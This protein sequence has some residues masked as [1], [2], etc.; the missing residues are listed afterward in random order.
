MFFDVPFD[1][2]NISLREVL[3]GGLDADSNSVYQNIVSY[4]ADEAFLQLINQATGYKSDGDISLRELAAHILLTACTRTISKDY[5]AGLERFIS[6][7]H[8]SYCY[9]FV[10]DWIRSDDHISFRYIAEEIERELRL[11]SRFKTMSIDSLYDTE[12]F[13][14]ISEIIL[15]KLMTDIQNEIIPAE[16]IIKCNEKRRT[17]VWHSDVSCYYDGLVAIADMQNFFVEHS[18]SF[19]LAVSEEIW[20]AYTSDYYKMDQY[21]RR[22]H[23]AFQKSLKMSNDLLDDLFKHVADKVEALYSGWYLTQ[24]ADNWTSVAGEDLEKYGHIPGIARQDEFY[25]DRIKNADSRVFV[26]ISDALRYEAAFSLSEQLRRETQSEVTIDSMCGIFP[27][28]TPFGM[29]ALLPHKELTVAA[30]A[31]E[32]LCVLADGQPTDSLNRDKVLKSANLDS[33]ALRYKNII[34]LKRAERS[35]LVKGM[36]VVYIYHD[37]IDETAHSSEN[38]VFTACDEAIDEIKNMVRIIVNEFGGARVYITADH[39]FLYTYKPLTEDE[40]VSK[41]GWNDKEAECGRRYCIMKNGE[42]PDY[43]DPSDTLRKFKHNMD[44]NPNNGLLPV[45]NIQE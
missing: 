18:E 6:T 9:D 36:D 24:L 39:G 5:F 32:K 10:S 37:K 44:Y 30:K 8:Q 1:L 40:K 16:H 43:L 4:G 33:V 41:S 12:V 25:I 26:I 31:N 17:M 14:C 42:K 38:A 28:I 2:F 3:K 21:Y 11:F 22:F 15:I 13:P 7:S 35:E 29:A 45:R 19:H 23:C 20:A 34:G 27:T